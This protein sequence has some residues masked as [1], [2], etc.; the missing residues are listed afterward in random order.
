MAK[1]IVGFV[2]FWE[3]L[4]VK[5]TRLLQSVLRW[6]NA[7]PEHYHGVLSRLMRQPKA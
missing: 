3:F 1:K 7:S 6:V 5:Q 2:R 4:R